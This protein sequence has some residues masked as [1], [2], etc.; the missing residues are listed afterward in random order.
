MPELPEVEAIRRALLPHLRGRTVR[1]AHLFRPEVAAYPDPQSFCARLRDMPIETLLRR[2]KYLG[3][4]SGNDTVLWLHFRMTG[5]LSCV[6]PGHPLPPHTHAVFLLDD[7]RELRFSDMRRFGRLW[8]LTAEEDEKI[9]GL[10]TL[11]PEPAD[12]TAAY[13]REALARR[14]RPIKSALLDQH[15]IA[16]LG[17][18]YTDEILHRA[19]ICPAR[20]AG[21]VREELERLTEVMVPTLEEAVARGVSCSRELFGERMPRAQKEGWKVYER[22]GKPCLTCG[23]PLTGARIGGRSTVWCPA[24]QK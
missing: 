9:A 15:L 7:G 13:L 23:T 21:T 4:Q 10:D 3:L 14:R 1:E 8:V 19:G 5:K 24:C 11:G 6:A 17:N 20:P 22:R 18:I 16:G 2:G 12:V